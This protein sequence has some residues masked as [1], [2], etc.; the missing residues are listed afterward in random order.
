MLGYQS[1]ITTLRVT[2]TGHCTILGTGD[3]SDLCVRWT[4]DVGGLEFVPLV[5]SHTL[6]VHKIFSYV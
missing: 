5:L 6:A 4:Q 1:P 3:A 2:G